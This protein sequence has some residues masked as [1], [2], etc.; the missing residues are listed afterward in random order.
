MTQDLDD[1]LRVN[2]SLRDRLSAEAQ[3][4]SGKKE[5]AEQALAAVRKEILDKKIDPDA[6]D[7]TIEKLE[8]AYEQAVNA[9]EA[10]VLA[11]KE[12]LK[13]YTENEV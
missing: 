3:K 5:A 6:L 9:F 2:L 11:A 7:E 1:R 8:A 12:A 10:E 13:P 4:I